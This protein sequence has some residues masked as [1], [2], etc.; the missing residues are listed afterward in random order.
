MLPVIQICNVP[1]PEGRLQS[2]VAANGAPRG[3]GIKGLHI[4][5]SAKKGGKQFRVEGVKGQ[6]DEAFR[7][8]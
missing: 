1:Q 5:N 2:S 3:H 8:I 6:P 4:Q 7:R